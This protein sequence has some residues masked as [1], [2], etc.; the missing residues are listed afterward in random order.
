[1]RSK[2][3]VTDSLFIFDE[4]VKRLEAA[5]FEVERLDKTYASKEEMIRALEGKQG[6][7][8][9]GIEKADDEVIKSAKNLKAISVL[10]S[11]YSDFLP[12]YKQATKQGIAVTSC[13]GAN[14]QAVAEYVLLLLLASVR[15]FKG[16]TTPGGSVFYSG[17]ELQ[18]LILGII[19]FGHVGPALAKLALA[20]GINVIVTSHHKES[21]PGVE[22]VDLPV[23]LKNS[24]VVSVHVNKIHG[25]GLLGKDELA[26]MKTGATLINCA[27]LEAVKPE[28]LRAELLAG[29]IKYAT[30]FKVDFKTEDLPQDVLI[31]TN[32]GNAF[33][34]QET[35]QRMSDRATN[36]M[37]N[38]LNTGKDTDVVNPEYK[39]YKS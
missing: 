29:R 37:I 28:P 26:I 35:L 4:H 23:L 1:M 11:G 22:L 27:F 39:N 9:G 36:S 3:L 13:P 18:S 20:L 31:Q 30:D 7:I 24:D 21:M 38:L 16:L 32:E 17:R 19:G 10:A 5:G 14:T 15:N 6:Y 25:E 34:T 12:S 8:C 2:I 33:N